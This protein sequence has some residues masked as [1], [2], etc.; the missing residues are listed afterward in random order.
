MPTSTSREW[1]EPKIIV[2]KHAVSARP[3]EPESQRRMFQAEM[4]EEEMLML[5][6]ILAAHEYYR[7]DARASTHR[8][9]VT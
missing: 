3:V 2:Q 6:R 1:P 7:P 4:T 5:S 8:G 9:R